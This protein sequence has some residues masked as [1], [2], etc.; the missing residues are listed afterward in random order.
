MGIKDRKPAYFIASDIRKADV[1]SL[2]GL[3]HEQPIFFGGNTSA[4]DKIA[5]SN[6]NS[7]N[8]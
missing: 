1:L 3:F 8:N 5:Q 4:N 7:N 2:T 6:E